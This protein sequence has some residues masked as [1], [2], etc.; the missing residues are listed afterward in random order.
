MGFAYNLGRIVSAFA[1]F[2]VGHLAQ[3]RGMGF[4]LMLTSF[5]FL[6]AGLIATGIRKE[7][8]GEAPVDGTLSGR[9][10]VSRSALARIESDARSQRSC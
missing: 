10:N 3:N 9:A 6:A 8:D 4:G 1:P 7:W 2:L 5:G